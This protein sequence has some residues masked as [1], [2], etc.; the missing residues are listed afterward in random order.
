MNR[1]IITLCVGMLL[2]L[3]ACADQPEP[4]VEPEHN[5]D[6]LTYEESVL[7]AADDAGL[8]TFTALVETAG[9]TDRLTH[10]G[11]YTVFAPSDE[12]FNA[13]DAATL[14]ALRDERNRDALRSILTYHIVS[15]SLASGDLVGEQSIATVNGESVTVTATDESV[16]LTD[17]QAN[18][19]TV[20]TADFT[21]QNGILHVIDTVLL[22]ASLDELLEREADMADD[23]VADDDATVGADDDVTETDA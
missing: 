5:D 17:R 18:T 7:G 2:L 9:L 21:A 13:L 3:G 20:I 15:D 12:A 6:Q 16:T 11:P 10:E 22:P 23:E 4:I 19:A 14:D 1:S 8:T